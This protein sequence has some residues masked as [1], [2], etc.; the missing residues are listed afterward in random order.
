M[1]WKIPCPSQVGYQNISSIKGR[2]TSKAA[3]G[4]QC[5]VGDFRLCRYQKVFLFFNFLNWYNALCSETQ[6][7]LSG[8]KVGPSHLSHPSNSSQCSYLIDRSHPVYPSHL[9]HSTYPTHPSHPSLP[10]HPSNPH[11]SQ[12]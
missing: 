10:S 11:L 8:D 6:G 2:M 3:G 1:F 9:S 4:W 12:S 7:Y 5:P